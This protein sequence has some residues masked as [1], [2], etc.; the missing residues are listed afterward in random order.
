[1]FTDKQN[2]YCD[3]QQIAGDEA[4]EYIIDHGDISALVQQ[5]ISKGKGRLVVSVGTA[6]EDLTSL[7]ISLRTAAAKTGSSSSVSLSSPVTL[8]STP[9][10]LL[11]DLA[12]AGKTLL[13]IPL[14]VGLDQYS[15]LYFTR[16]GSAEGHGTIN[17]MIVVDSQINGAY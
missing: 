14:P 16:V 2:I 12:V 6:F 5:K 1:M 17:A 3:D 9:A 11:A 4:S 15:D 13:D 10:I 8:F 7:V